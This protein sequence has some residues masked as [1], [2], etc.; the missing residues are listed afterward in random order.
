MAIHI[1]LVFIIV[2]TAP[3]VPKIGKYIPAS[4]VGILVSTFVEW[5]IIRPNGGRTPIIGEVG[6]VS[7]GLPIP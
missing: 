5:V 4:L 2:K 1:V 6:R 7:G 3:L